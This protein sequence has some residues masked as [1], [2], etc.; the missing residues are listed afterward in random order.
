MGRILKVILPVALCLVVVASVALV[1]CAEE[2]KAPLEAP[3]MVISQY[4]KGSTA[5][6]DA[7]VINTM[8]EGKGEPGFKAGTAASMY[9]TYYFSTASRDAKAKE[10]YPDYRGYDTADVTYALLG[11]LESS[12][13][14]GAILASLS[15]AEKAAVDTAVVGFID[16]IDADMSD[17]VAPE[18]TSAYEILAGVSAEAADGWAADVEAGM[19]LADRFFVWLVKE[20]VIAYHTYHV[21]DPYY[22]ALFGYVPTTPTDEQAEAVARIAGELFF[23][24]GTASATYPV[25]A[26]AAAQARYGKS[27]AACDEMQKGYVDADVYGALPSVFASDAERDMYRD[28]TALMLALYT[29]Y[30][31]PTH[32]TYALCTGMEKAWV[33]YSLYVGLPDAA[34]DGI[35]EVLAA[36]G[37]IDATHTTFAACT[38]AEKAIVNQAASAVGLPSGT[39]LE[40]DYID[41]AAVPGFFMGVGAELTDALPLEQNIAYLTLKSKVSPAAAEG[42]KADV[43]ATVPVHPRQAFYRW[44]AKEAVSAMAA[45]A[46]LI[47]LSVAEF[48]IKVTN[49]NEYWISLD[50]LTVN[51]S[52]DVEWYPGT[53]NMVA[54]DVAKVVLNEK[55][56]VPPMEDDVEGEVTVRLLA[57]VKVYDVITWGV[58]AGYDQTKAGGLA[59]FAFDK[60]QAGTAVWDMTIDA[61]ISAETGT[62]TESYDLQWPTA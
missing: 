54:V 35:A 24:N 59:T 2:E 39:A 44:L 26:D 36:A 1:G 48:S 10:L 49:P 53:G 3:V 61:V 56:W 46:P 57:P 37:I 17:A 52:I 51:A 13:V 38:D 29:P 14:D 20:A 6:F 30:V 21:F 60:I 8:S 55:V 28:N 33:N 11:D 62:I 12:A 5:D 15:A 43:T 23:T 50:S 34:R 31:D 45:A 19:D 7:G 9:P 16:R 27:Y 47:R 41:L 18:E 40:R 4:L 22:L 25:E 32:T 58:M 42:W